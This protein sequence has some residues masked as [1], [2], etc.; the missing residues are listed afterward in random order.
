MDPE[1]YCLGFERFNPH[2]E[3]T[4]LPSH[5]P[6]TGQT[7]TC[8]AHLSVK[9]TITWLYYRDRFAAQ[10]FFGDVM[11]WPSVLEQRIASIHPASRSGLIG[12]VAA[13]QGLHPYSE[14]KG[15]TVSLF[16]EQIDAWFAD[17]QKQHYIVQLRPLSRESTH[18]LTSRSGLGAQS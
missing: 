1:G 17:L 3:N 10:R 2:P 11:G 9:A 18:A 13:G 5:Y 6:V 16:T 15:V 14:Q 4:W 7:T 12:R 8:P